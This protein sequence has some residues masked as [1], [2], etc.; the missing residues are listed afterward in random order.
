V[1][2]IVRLVAI[3]SALSLVGAGT[4]AARGL[5]ID[6]GVVQSVSATRIVLRELDGS[7]V[8]IAVG[9]STRVLLNGQPAGLLDI[10]PGFVAAV[11]HDGAAPARVIRAFGRVQPLVD[12]GVVVSMS[13]R[14]L[15]IRTAAGDKL[16]FRIT[17]RTRFR[18]RRL[19]ATAAAVRAGRIVD[20]AH[21]QDGVAVR[22]IVRGSRA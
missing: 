15:V 20:V 12:R 8:E 5:V 19:P 3:L 4:A 17:P 1:R 16:A 18:W 6:R 22:V 13:P 11:G 9:P 10:Q 2:S 14:R 21:R 7:T